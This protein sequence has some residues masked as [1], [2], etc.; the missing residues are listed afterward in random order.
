MLAALRGFTTDARQ[1]RDVRLHLIHCRPHGC[2]AQGEAPVDRCLLNL[3]DVDLRRFMTMTPRAA[4][5]NLD[6]VVLREALLR[7]AAD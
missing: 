2:E 5:A 1:A 3:P 4:I 7:P 6:P